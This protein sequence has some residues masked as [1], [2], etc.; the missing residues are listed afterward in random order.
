MTTS[1]EH[2]RY[3]R[4]LGR[5]VEAMAEECGFEIEFGGSMTFQR[6]GLE[7]GLEPDECYWITHEPQMRG[8]LSW[9]AK[10]DPPPDLVLEIEISRNILDR[11]PIYAALGIP[12]IWRFNGENIRVLTL[13]PDGKYQ[14]SESSPTFPRIPLAAAVKFLDPNANQGN[15]SVIRSFRTW[16]QT[17]LQKP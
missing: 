2:E 11:I 14:E 8:K 17:Q 15:V 6:E 13:R 5:L 10:Q 12:E 1:P 16:L 4:W 7:K 9:D 3:K